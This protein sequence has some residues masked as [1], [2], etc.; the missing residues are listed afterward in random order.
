LSGSAL[1]GEDVSFEVFAGS[2]HGVQR[3]VL[4]KAFRDRVLHAKNLYYHNTVDLEVRKNQN[5]QKN[6]DEEISRVRRCYSHW[7]LD[8]NYRMRV[9][10]Y[11]TKPTNPF[12]IVDLSWN[13]REGV[14]KNTFQSKDMEGRIFGR[15]D[16]QIDHIVRFNDCFTFWLQGGSLEDSV[17]HPSYL[18]P[19]L[20]E[21]EERWVIVCLLEEGNIQ[22]SFEFD[23]KANVFF[24]G[25][26]GQR[27]LVLNPDKAFLPVEGM[28]RRSVHLENGEL[29]WIE[30]NFYVEESQR[31]SH[32]WM[33][34]KLKTVVRDSSM[35]GKFSIRRVSV[36]DISHGSVTESDVSLTFPE[37]TEVVD[38]IEGV[39]Y[40][41]DAKG[42]AILRNEWSVRITEEA[43]KAWE[44]YLNAWNNS[45]VEFH[46]RGT[47][48]NTVVI[49]TKGLFV[50]SYP[51]SF[52]LITDNLT[53]KT[54][55]FVSNNKY[56]FVLKKMSD[57]PW[58][59][60][61]ITND[62]ILPAENGIK[63]PVLYEDHVTMVERLVGRNF[64]KGLMVSVAD[65]F[66]V[67]FIQ[68]EF[69]ILDIKEVSE[70]GELLIYLKYAYSPQQRPNQLVRGGEI[71][72]MPNLYWLIKRANVELLDPNGTRANASIICEYDF[73]ETIP[74]LLRHT[75]HTKEY[76]QTV[77]RSFSNYSVKD[78]FPAG[79]FTLSHY[80][81]PEPDFPDFGE[82]RPS[83][84][85]YVL[86]AIG[87]I[88][89]VIAL[90]RMYQTRKGTES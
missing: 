88:M 20:L 25:G 81:F 69:Q 84:T 11:P 58:D 52:H 77:Q 39:A 28:A 74:R 37:G 61:S 85:Q 53:S 12:Q 49:D 19:H 72:L 35:P 44:S 40:K 8:I 48:D 90:W 41:T 26:T 82:R 73:T 79:E 55:I 87:V 9:E 83:R 38:A 70:D 15:I 43:P 54:Y 63:F 57:D 78:T 67:V 4:V 62:F 65:W 80:G 5:G 13:S 50:F 59:I 29:F 66:P 68:P 60:D 76:N 6:E 89:I 3:L 36:S 42:N 56:E 21:N 14:L 45:S 17:S 34:T 46:E 86:A 2:P 32:V 64:A 10:I 30:E 1:C 24:E 71:W 22:L 27:T 51:N 16:T 75:F 23:P 18:F 7:Q 33:P 47:V 31:V